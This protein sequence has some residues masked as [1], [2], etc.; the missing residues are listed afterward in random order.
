MPQCE[1]VAE[2]V[3]W[4]WAV[5]ASCAALL[6]VIFC[7]KP[8][9]FGAR[10]LL[11]SITAFSAEDI[12]VPTNNFA[13]ATKVRADEVWAECRGVCRSGRHAG[14]RIACGQLSFIAGLF[15]CCFGVFAVLRNQEPKVL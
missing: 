2:I 8:I 1:W 11:G 14:L 7:A 3:A 5:L 15:A 13:A 10:L 12:G 6:K 9:Q 4:P